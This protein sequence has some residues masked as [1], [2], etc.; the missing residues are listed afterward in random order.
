M[1]EYSQAPSELGR[2]AHPGALHEVGESFSSSVPPEQQVK[3][4]VA[5]EEVLFPRLNAAVLGLGRRILRGWQAPVDS[6][7]TRRRARR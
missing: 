4:T 3:V 1:A 6:P 5:V 7:L 2:K